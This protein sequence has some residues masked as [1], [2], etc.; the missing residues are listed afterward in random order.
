[1][2]R[3]VHLSADAHRDQRLDFLEV[4]LWVVLSQSAWVLGTKLHFPVRATCTVNF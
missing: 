3:Y 1:M 2:C 4:E